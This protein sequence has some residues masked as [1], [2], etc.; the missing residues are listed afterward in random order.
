MLVLRGVM[1]SFFF[2]M[3]N[4]YVQLVD[5]VYQQIVGILRGTNC[6]PLIADFFFNIFMRATF[7]NP[8][9]KTS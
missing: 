1:L 6:A 2:P 9:F 3:D 7:T 8:N 4:I 5:M